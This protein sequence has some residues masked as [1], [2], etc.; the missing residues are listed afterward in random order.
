ML[1]SLPLQPAEIESL[2]ST[3]LAPLRPDRFLE[4]LQML[5]FPLNDPRVTG[6]SV[7]WSFRLLKL[8][9]HRDGEDTAFYRDFDSIHEQPTWIYIPNEPGELV[10]G[11]WFRHSQRYHDQALLVRKQP[12]KTVGCHPS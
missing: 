3:S 9:A 4:P 8:H 6:Y 11:I 2:R 1:W 5:P 7:C 10:T 12:P